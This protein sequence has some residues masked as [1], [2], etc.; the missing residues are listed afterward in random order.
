LTKISAR[1]IGSYACSHRFW[2][3]FFNASACALQASYSALVAGADAI[4]FFLAKHVDSLKLPKIG[5]I[6]FEIDVVRFL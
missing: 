3:I 2:V 1:H 6:H 4:S 5:K